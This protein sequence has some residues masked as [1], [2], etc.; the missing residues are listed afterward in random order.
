MLRYEIINSLIEENGFK[1]YLEIGVSDPRDCFD[2]IVC[3]NKDSVDPGVEFAENPVKYKMTSDDFFHF[4]NTNNLDKHP[5][6]KWDIIFIDGLHISTQVMKD[7]FNA[8]HHLSWNGYIVLHDCNP[9]SSHL[10][11][12]DYYVNGK[13]EPWN[14]TVWKT[15]YWLRA[16][17]ADISMEVVDT[18]W[19][20]GIIK[21]QQ[22]QPI[23]FDNPFY[24][25]NQMSKNRKRD[26]G[27]I[28]VN[29]FKSKYFNL[30]KSEQTPKFNGAVFSYR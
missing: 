25:Y 27:L 12:E 9:P 28:S 17:R 2:K 21:K 29:E 7:V 22:S 15:I 4:L 18:D 19:G 1:N 23:P 13:Q 8:L 20:V 16:H 24:E 26:L 10:A 30:K 6:F 3:Q 14:G 11:R 5:D